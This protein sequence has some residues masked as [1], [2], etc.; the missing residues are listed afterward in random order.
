[1]SVSV[2][3]FLFDMSLC[4]PCKTEIGR[5]YP[6]PASPREA[7]RRD[8]DARIGGWMTGT[9]SPGGSRKTRSGFEVLT[10]RSAS[11]FGFLQARRVL[12]P[13]RHAPGASGGP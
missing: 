10:V 12:H 13:G 2:S 1:M 4:A 5:S 11:V 7:R 9:P 8:L 3:N 6:I